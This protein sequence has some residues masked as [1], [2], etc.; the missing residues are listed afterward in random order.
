MQLMEERRNLILSEIKKTGVVYVGELSKK[1]NVSYETIRKDLSFLEK[2]GLLIKQ[3]GGA[4]LKQ[5][6]VEHPFQT[7]ELE[8]NDS[9]QLLAK[10]AF[11]L[12]P[13]KSSLILGTGSTIV[14]LAKLFIGQ[15]GYKIFTDSLPIAEI[16]LATDNQVSF[17]GGKLRKNSSSVYGGWTVNQIN[18]VRVDLCFLGTDGFANFAGP[19]SPS[20]SDAFIDQNILKVAEKSYI[21]GDKSKFNKKSLYNI[22]D[23]Q[24]I[25]ALITDKEESEQLT[26]LKK[27]TKVITC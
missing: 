19:T 21:L 9:K 5:H 18:Q 17:F 1:Y 15:K 10:K 26:E 2:Q 3:H 6:S 25:T 11:T 23:W 27:K 20:S 12:I 14:E 4:T 24:K 7:R 16:L 22:C 13:P 8:N